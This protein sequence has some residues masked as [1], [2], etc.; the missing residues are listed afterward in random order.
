MTAA[1]G[2]ALLILAAACGGTPS[3]PTLGPSPELLRLVGGPQW[4]DLLGFG[5]SDDPDY[6]ACVPAFVPRDG[7]HVAT[8]VVLAR[9]GGEWVARAL[10]AATS[11][12]VLSF[13]EAGRS[14]LGRTVAGTLRGWALNVPRFT[15]ERP[16]DVR[17]AVAGQGLRGGA[18]VEGTVPPLDS[19]VLGS[20]TGDIRFSDA[21]MTASSSCSKI[22]W[23]LQPVT[24][25]AIPGGS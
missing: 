13:H 19:F 17:V 14:V 21:A 2:L 1:A 8:Q 4:L 25:P 5:L 9:E 7:T 15:L 23:T 18:A 3:S 20:V 12:M 11:S 16:R 22:Q 10:D 24:P 6:P